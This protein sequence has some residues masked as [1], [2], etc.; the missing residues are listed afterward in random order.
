MSFK[1]IGRVCSSCTNGKVEPLYGGL[2]YREPGSDWLC[3]S[4]GEDLQLAWMQGLCASC[5]SPFKRIL[6]RNE[7]LFDRCDSCLEKKIALDPLHV[8]QAH[9]CKKVFLKG[10]RFC[11]HEVLKEP[12]Y[13]YCV[14]CSLYRKWGGG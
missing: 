13:E 9:D 4:C 5:R 12:M 2:A 8:I 7:I 10:S 14:A 11:P 6:K 1:S 3:P